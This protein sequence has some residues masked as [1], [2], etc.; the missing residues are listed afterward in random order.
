MCSCLFFWCNNGSFLFLH[1]T[2]LSCWSIF[3]TNM[4]CFCNK[5]KVFFFED[6]KKSKQQQTPPTAFV[7]WDSKAISSNRGA[8]GR[9]GGSGLRASGTSFKQE[10]A[11]RVTSGVSCRVYSRFHPNGCGLGAGGGRSPFNQS[12]FDGCPRV[13]GGTIPSFPQLGEGVTKHWFPRGKICFLK[14][15]RKDLQVISSLEVQK[16]DSVHAW[17]GLLVLFFFFFLFSATL[18]IEKIISFPTLWCV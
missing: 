12:A 9:P 4:D 13:G 5:Y 7:F 8:D 2:C 3:M 1:S 10:G 17:K 16:R 6:W 14:P 15:Q 11:C 18:S